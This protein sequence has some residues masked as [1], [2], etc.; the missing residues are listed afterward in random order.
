[1][2]TAEFVAKIYF[3]YHNIRLLDHNI[4]IATVL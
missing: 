3:F 2:K 4:D 1:M